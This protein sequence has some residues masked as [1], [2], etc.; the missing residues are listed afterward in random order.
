M[1]AA[2]ENYC[3]V[4]TTQE[5]KA[6]ATSTVTAFTQNLLGNKKNEPK[7]IENEVTRIDVDMCKVEECRVCSIKVEG[8][9]SKIGC[10]EDYESFAIER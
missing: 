2:I 7:D 1:N 4:I 10:T 5:K 8:N 6:N 3:D 9:V